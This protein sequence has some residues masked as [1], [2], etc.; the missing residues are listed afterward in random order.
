MNS[1]KVWLITGA[2]RGMGVDIAKAALAAGHDVVATGR[3]PEKVRS[4]IGDHDNLLVAQLDV[5]SPADAEAAV[6]T[7]V[8]RFGRIDVL[9]NNAGNFYGGFFEELSP[10]Q[11]RSQL[12]TLLFGPMNVAR[13]VLP[14][15]RRQRSGLLVTISSTAGII[16][17][18]FSAAGRCGVGTGTMAG[19]MGKRTCRGSHHWAGT[20]DS[21]VAS[22]G[23][24]SYGCSH[25][26]G[27]GFRC[28]R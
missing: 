20:R 23:C 13:A 14:V 3:N 10:V 12:E 9:V 5:T 28:G 21:A 1:K 2:G 25:R 8:Q 16:A 17:G 26:R 15:M 4:A 11:V 7:T 22:A 18:V 24:S 27:A 19:S 6:E